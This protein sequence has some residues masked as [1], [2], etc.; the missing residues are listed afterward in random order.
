[1]NLVHAMNVVA[2]YSGLAKFG[3][4]L[5]VTIQKKSK[6]EKLSITGF[7]PVVKRLSLM[8][9]C[10]FFELSVICS[11]IPILSIKSFSTGESVSSSRFLYLSY[12]A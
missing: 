9:K 5:I 6:T 2:T 1:M 10:Y 4:V 8:K 12:S 11:N 7:V 3:N